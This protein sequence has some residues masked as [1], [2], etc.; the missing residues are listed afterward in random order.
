MPARPSLVFERG[1]SLGWGRPFPEIGRPP[2]SHF[3]LPCTQTE[4][5]ADTLRSLPSVRWFGKKNSGA[6][7]KPRSHAVET[8][9]VGCL[10]LSCGAL[11]VV[12]NL[13]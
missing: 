8:G 10:L 4:A 1:F 6:R 5:I 12:A 11:L 2:A 13:E 7:P 3:Q 9:L